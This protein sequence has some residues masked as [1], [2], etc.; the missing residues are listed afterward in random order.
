MA[1]HILFRSLLLFTAESIFDC[2][3]CRNYKTL[4]CGHLC[5]CR[6]Y[7]SKVPYRINRKL[8]SL[9]LCA[10]ERRGNLSTNCS[11][12]LISFVKL[13]LRSRDDKEESNVLESYLSSRVF[14][15]FSIDRC[16]FEALSSCLPSR[17]RRKERAEKKISMPTS[18][19]AV[20]IGIMNKDMF[21]I[22]K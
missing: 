3:C 6:L 16:G 8:I 10:R 13:I 17:F 5:C 12:D 18:M 1:P 20:F 9:C 21:K 2:G 4:H 22:C 7:R 11:S 15:S 19:N 14:A